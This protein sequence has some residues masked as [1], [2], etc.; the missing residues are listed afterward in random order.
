[1]KLHRSLAVLIVVVLLIWALVPPP[2]SSSAQ[3]PAESAATAPVQVAALANGQIAFFDPSAKR[4]YVYGADLR[5]S[6]QVVEID[7]LG[8]PLRLVQRSGR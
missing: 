4:L 3:Q 2:R 8:R 7:Q 1:M 6:V 5:T